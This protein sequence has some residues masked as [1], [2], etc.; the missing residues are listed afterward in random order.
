MFLPSTPGI[1]AADLEVTYINLSIMFRLPSKIPQG[2]GTHRDVYGAA[3]AYVDIDL[4]AARRTPGSSVI[5]LTH[6][7][8]GVN[9]GHVDL[10]AGKNI[11]QCP[12]FEREN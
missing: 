4:D 10:T 12:H 11:S 7:S 5:P 3:S 8:Q 9:Q 2:S 1:L 6:H